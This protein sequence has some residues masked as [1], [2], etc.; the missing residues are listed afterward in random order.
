V[1][2]VVEE[3][4]VG[5]E[6]VAEAEVAVVVSKA[7]QGEPLRKARGNFATNQLLLRF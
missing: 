1:V 7:L 3:V 5:E 4:V 6:G 2:G